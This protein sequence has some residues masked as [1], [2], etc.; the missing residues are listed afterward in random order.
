VGL[1]SQD[2]GGE[3][4]SGGVNPRRRADHPEGSHSSFLSKQSGEWW[5]SRLAVEGPKGC[6][7]KAVGG[8]PLHLV[9]EG[10]HSSGEG[11]VGYEPVCAVGED[12]ENKSHC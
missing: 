12:W 10:V 9:P 3:A 1:P 6:G 5:E 7:P 11:G 8:P 2:R 4:C